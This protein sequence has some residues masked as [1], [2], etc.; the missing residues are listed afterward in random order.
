MNLSRFASA[1]ILML[2]SSA[3]ISCSIGSRPS[4]EVVAKADAI[5]RARITEVRLASGSTERHQSNVEAQFELLEN[6]KG[7]P[8]RQLRMRLSE[9]GECG[10]FHLIVGIEYLLVMY[11]GQPPVVSGASFPVSRH[12]PGSGPRLEEFRQLAKVAK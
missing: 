5:F 1:A 4:A 10:E 12:I 11:P 2:A 7:V 8:P 6:L 3:A 9:L